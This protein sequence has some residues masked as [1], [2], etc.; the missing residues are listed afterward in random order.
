[1]LGKV[2]GDVERQ[3]VSTAEA[4]VGRAAGHDHPPG[5]SGW[6][7]ACP[8]CP[9]QL[10]IRWWP[11][12]EEWRFRLL[13]ASCTASPS[14]LP[15]HA[16][17]PAPASLLQVKGLQ[18]EY[19]RMVDSNPAGVGAKVSA[20]AAAAQPAGPAAG[21]A[22]AGGLSEGEVAELRRLLADLEQQNSTLQVTR[23]QHSGMVVVGLGLVGLVWE[24][25]EAPA[26]RSGA[27][28]QHA[29]GN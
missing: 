13:P 15:R 2:L 19:T 24:V 11:G 4:C 8:V 9:V 5:C 28:E 20:G 26:G 14:S 16:P 6:E 1:M 10:L 23:Q 3:S 17:P 25:A 12:V 7:G 21:A 29:A 22:A 18:S 27:A